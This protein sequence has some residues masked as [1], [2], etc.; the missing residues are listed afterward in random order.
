LKKLETVLLIPLML[1]GAFLVPTVSH[2]Q[3][4]GIVSINGGMEVTASAGQTSVQVPVSISGSDSFNGFSIQIQASTSYLVGASV[5]TAGSVL[6]NPTILSE[7]INGVYIAGNTCPLENQNG[8]VA[9]AAANQAGQSAASGVSGLLFT[10]TYTITGLTTGTPIAFNTGCP[11]TSTGNSDCVE[12]VLGSATDLELD[13]PTTF[14]NLVDFSMTPAYTMLSTASGVP[15]SDPINYTAL[16]GFQDILTE[17]ISTTGG[18]S[19]SIASGTPGTVDLTV[20]PYSAIDTLTCSGTSSG[21]AT[22]NATGQGVFYPTYPIKTHTVNIP[23]AIEPSGFSTSLINSITQMSQASVDVAAGNSNSSTT[24]SLTGVSG[25][26]GTVVFTATSVTGITGSAPSVTLTPNGSGYSSATTTLTVTVASTV[27]AGSYTLTLTATSDPSIV[28]AS[29]VVNVLTKDFEVI[30]NPNSIS[31]VRGGSVGST[32]TLRSEGNFAG[33]A[34]LTA[35]VSPVAGQQDSCCLTNNTI[36]SFSAT[37]VSL[38]SG[39]FVSVNFGVSTVGGSAAASSYTATGNYTAIITATIGSDVH[40]AEIDFTVYDFSVGPTFCPGSNLVAST[41]SDFG[42]IDNGGQFLNSTFAGIYIGSSCSSLT[43]T[44]QPNI[45][46]LFLNGALFGDVP[47][48]QFLW[49]R[50]NTYGGT[51]VGLVTNG[52]NGTPSI[53]ASNTQIPINGVAI[54]QL[55]VDFPANLTANGFS[56]PDFACLLPTFWAN[57]TQIPYSYLEANGPLIIPGYGITPWL[58]TIA[59]TTFTP[60]GPYGNWGCKY[61][62]AAYPNDAGV[63]ADNAGLG[64]NIPRYNNPDYFMV[65]AMAINGTLPGNYSFQFCGQAGILRHC[66]TYGLTVVGAPVI[67]LTAPKVVS[68][69]HSRGKIQFLAFFYN[70]DHG[71]T[72]YVEATATGIGTLGDTITVTTPVVELRAGFFSINFSFPTATISKAMIGETFT[73]TFSMAV[74]TDPVNLDGTSTLH[75]GP[76]QFTVHI[77]K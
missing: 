47:L 24:V 62:A 48:G 36:A 1:L 45:V 9:L 32:I 51:N 7:C 77:T 13:Q 66:E 19:C 18:I 60:G 28:V 76:S 2:A 69:K 10:I 25:L 56:Y 63:A 38:S 20:S 22:V 23:V 59:P 44:D 29:L 39:G 55:A 41:P 54:P 70:P 49:I 26:S 58:S 8:V 33:A 53:A 16:G 57:G 72:E 34:T 65:Q 15:I 35:T 11:P 67:Y 50:T 5:S 68:Y 21:T 40:T 6:P 37:T 17:T 71:V 61:D 12:I 75:I 4:T 52:Y 3:L 73:F 64:T 74:G 27:A 31:I 43:I 14:A 42:D 30:A 46:P